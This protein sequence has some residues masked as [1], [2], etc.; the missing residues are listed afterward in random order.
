VKKYDFEKIKTILT[1]MV[2]LGKNSSQ[3]HFYQGRAQKN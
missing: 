2:P 3:G 1:K